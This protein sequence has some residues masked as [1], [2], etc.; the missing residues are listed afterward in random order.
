MTRK[1]IVNRISDLEA[2]IKYCQLS[3]KEMRFERTQDDLD[4]NQ[5]YRNYQIEEKEAVKEIELLRAKL[6]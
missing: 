2:K 3:M 6:S 4:T 5:L 1:Q